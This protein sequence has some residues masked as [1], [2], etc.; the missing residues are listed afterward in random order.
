MD[1][2]YWTLLHQN[3][4]SDVVEIEPYKFCVMNSTPLQKYSLYK[5]AIL[6]WQYD[7]DGT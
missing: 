7:D 1:S 4:Q 2:I 5:E 3:L 6:R